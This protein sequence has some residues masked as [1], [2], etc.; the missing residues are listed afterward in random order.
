M[1]I[2]DNDEVVI[3]LLDMLAYFFQK[4]K[5]LL[6]GLV[7]GVL[8]IGCPLAYRQYRQIQNKYADTTLDAIQENMTKGEI[9][10]VN[11]LY[12]RYKTFRKRII[13]NQYYMDHSILMKMD[14]NNVS[15]YSVKYVFEADQRTAVDYFN[16]FSLNLDEYNEIAR[17]LGNDADPRFAYEVLGI[18]CTAAADDKIIDADMPDKIIVNGDIT[19]K[20]RGLVT[21]SIKA[22]NRDKCEKIAEIV[23]NA[24]SKAVTELTDI[25]VTVKLTQS[26]VNYTE[27]VDTGLVEQQQSRMAMGSELV[28]SYNA[29]EKDNKSSLNNQEQKLFEYMIHHDDFVT[30]R[31]SWKK[32]V[33]IGGFAGA[34]AVA[35]VLCLM[36]LFAGDFKTV[37]DVSRFTGIKLVGCI[38]RKE[39][40]FKGLDKLFLGIA[41]SIK[42]RGHA[43][44]Q[45][46]EAAAVTVTRIT[47]Y[48][49]QKNIDHIF[50]ARDDSSD[51]AKT[52]T[53][54]MVND[55][56]SQISDVEAGDP[57]KSPEDLKKL[58][59]SDMV[60]RMITLDKARKLALKELQ[61]MCG[62]VS[63]PIFG[64]VVI[65]NS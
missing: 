13:N 42:L 56:K 23:D 4:W 34:F 64:D 48:C 28:A 9:E 24:F 22:S 15:N 10:T 33:V 17:I 50:I 63:I 19:Y 49:K 44:Q 1:G 30:E 43:E 3:D 51:Y 53:D 40:P 36:Y 20:Y 58:H 39:K 62:E 26:G 12:N 55:L 18:Q 37:E 45:D 57:L 32:Y 61:E 5:Y 41:K 47:E 35:V 8:L 6:A 11:Q 31:P 27:S 7:L 54:Q 59:S 16:S 38:Y 25:G 52:I 65:I 46:E 14:P 29:F 21:L 60:V 2:N